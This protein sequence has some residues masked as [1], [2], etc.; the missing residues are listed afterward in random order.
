[1]PYIFPNQILEQ[2]HSKHVAIEEN[3]TP[4]EGSV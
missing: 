2:L 4:S 1:M 3:K